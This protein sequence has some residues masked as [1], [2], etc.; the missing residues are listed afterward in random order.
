M[1]VRFTLPRIPSFSSPPSSSPF[2]SPTF[3]GS[4]NF[5][6]YSGIKMS[7]P[8]STEQQLQRLLAKQ[9]GHSGG[10]FLDNVEHGVGSLLDKA[11]NVISRPNW[12]IASAVD[13]GTK[14]GSWL[15]G[16][17]SGITGHTHT[18][19]GDVLAHHHILDNHK[20]IRA[21]L[22]LG[23]DVATDPTTYLFGA[24]LMED[25]GK[26]GV[27]VG[28]HDIEKK[29]AASMAEH[30]GPFQ[31]ALA[32]HEQQVAER[33]LIGKAAAKV[34]DGK[35][36]TPF[37]KFQLDA[38]ATKTATLER[39][40]KVEHD[41][42]KKKY[43]ELRLGITKG[44]SVG[45][46]T[47]IRLR[48]SHAAILEATGKGA[49]L[50]H[51]IGKTF[52]PGYE[53]PL[54]H[55][56]LITA[57]HQTERLHESFWNTVA[58]PIMEPFARTMSEHDMQKALFAGEH[59]GT[60]NGARVLVKEMR[61]R[62]A[63][64]GFQGPQLEEALNFTKAWH[65]VTQ[66]LLQSEKLAGVK[67]AEPITDRLYVPHVYDRAQMG[68]PATISQIGQKGFEKARTAKDLTFQN[69]IKL[70][71]RNGFKG[72]AETNPISL[73]AA[74][75]R[76]GATGAATA[77]LRETLRDAVGVTERVYNPALRKQ[78]FKRVEARQAKLDAVTQEL[79]QAPKA[80]H[81]ARTSLGIRQ[82]K[83]LRDAQQAIQDAK[84]QVKRLKKRGLGPNPSKT[85]K[86]TRASRIKAAERRVTKAEKHLNE[87][88]PA[89]HIEEKNAL[90]LTHESKIHQLSLEKQQLED[91]ITK[92]SASARRRMWQRNPA[93]FREGLEHI[94]KLDRKTADG[95]VVKTRI[96]AHLAE[97]IDRVEHVLTNDEAMAR[98]TKA[99]GKA[100][101]EWKMLVTTINP[102]YR[103][104]NT[105]SDFWNMYIA[106][107]PTWAMPV[108]GKKA[109][110]LMLKAA[111]RKGTEAEQI[112]AKKMLQKAHD[113]GVLSGLFLGDVAEQTKRL[114]G[115]T[116]KYKRVTGATVH[117]NAMAE[118][119]G[120]LVHYLY[121][122]EREGMHPSAAAQQVRMAHFDY[123]DLTQTEQRLFKPYIPFYTWTRKNVPYQLQQLA[124]RPG[125]VATYTKAAQ[126]SEQASGVKPGDII[127]TA[128]QGHPLA[129]K[130]G[131]GYLD[132]QIG[133]ADLA[134]V[135]DKNQM[136]SMVTPA[137]GVP[138]QLA[139]NNNWFTG[140]K[141]RDTHALNPTSNVLADI[142]GNLPIIDQLF[143]KTTRFVPG[144][145]YER[146]PGINPYADFLLGQ[147]PLVNYLKNKDNPLRSSSES[148][149][150]L[151]YI[152][153]ISYVTPNPTAEKYYA[154]LAQSDYLKQAI[155]QL[156]DQG[157]FPE[158]KKRK[159]SDFQKILDGIAY[160]QIGRR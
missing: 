93:A 78:A 9:Q 57:R 102:G 107:V 152:G 38:E 28:L 59:A 112:A 138:I 68:K 105:L 81:S 12:A 72:P 49:Q 117:A 89:K 122:I 22:G 1:S 158:P 100:T 20:W 25:A 115:Q 86:A 109:T 111:G 3:G 84:D 29:G 118:N 32:V 62:L 80:L 160:S 113:H 27:K 121:R 26:F 103:I 147:V 74:R 31:K 96:P 67:H 143:G 35:K 8:P 129:F 119:W 135:T 30:A 46:R 50:R 85:A 98:L 131:S 110:D 136:L 146:G 154:Q 13:R 21:G 101:S 149:R 36:L 151:S 132:P 133:L 134:R 65:Q 41:L 15:K 104:R 33:N 39:M 139:T 116:S 92:L 24:G 77:N 79:N 53:D 124:S 159:R 5:N 16:F 148:N 17:E 4:V 2:S 48:K 128:L 137:L 54:A 43:L 141:I 56:A 75:I 90:G 40:A 44:K 156:R 42:N 23:L 120:R 45:L 37:E 51:A 145:G 95:L 34:A 97:N 144:K 82:Q 70:A 125:R 142:G 69:Q 87:T 55:A 64:Q 10:S 73:L 150:D 7:A 47:P 66:H 52:L 94:A 6:P 130:F 60:V 83:E 153:G 123:E 106:G 126:E 99:V 140:N 155:Q 114:A 11:M 108:Y 91:M 19:F 61:A 63:E 14:G 88:L 71:G 58:K 76:Q 18:T 157:L 127:G